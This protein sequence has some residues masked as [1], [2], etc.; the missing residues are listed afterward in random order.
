MGCKV[1]S[2]RIHLLGPSGFAFVTAFALHLVSPSPSAAQTYTQTCS[3]ASG[4]SIPVLFN[5]G[6]IASYGYDPDAFLNSVLNAMSVWNE[7]AG[8][9]LDLYYG[10]TT[11][12]QVGTPNAI[13]V[14]GTASLAG[15]CPPPP[16]GTDNRLAVTFAPGAGACGGGGGA[17]PV[18][19][20]VMENGC[21]PSDPRRFVIPWTTLWPLS[22]QFGVEDGTFVRDHDRERRAGDQ[23]GRRLSRGYG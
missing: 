1:A 17:G 15:A 18:I 22:T 5:A 14:I 21:A 13:T 12:L 10:G 11:T 6:A 23:L 2:S 7:E 3:W 19:R 16:M 8:A 9:N 4:S 20:L